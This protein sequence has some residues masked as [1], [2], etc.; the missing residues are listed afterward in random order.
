[1]T[2]PLGY[3]HV[4]DIKASVERLLEAGAKAQQAIKDVG[5]GKKVP[6]SVG[7]RWR[8]DA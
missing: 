5:G 6:S 4:D 1:M 7:S 2:G 8:H 3:W